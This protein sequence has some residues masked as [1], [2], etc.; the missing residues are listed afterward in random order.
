MN[1]TQVLS[2]FGQKEQKTKASFKPLKYFL[3]N[4]LFV[5]QKAS[6]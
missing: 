3:K 1:F 4:S 2:H 6:K 5:L